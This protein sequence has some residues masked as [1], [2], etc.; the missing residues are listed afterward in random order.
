[1]V[2]GLKIVVRLQVDEKFCRDAEAE[3]ESK[4]KGS[5]DS[6]F[7]TDYITQLGFTDLHRLCRLNLCNAVMLQGV[8]DHSGGRV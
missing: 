5:A 4:G 6:L 7:L 2:S 1:M 3:L 8:P